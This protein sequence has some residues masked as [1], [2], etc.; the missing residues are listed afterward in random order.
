MIMEEIIKR[1]LAR[2][3]E[4]LF[5]KE[6]SSFE[7]VGAYLSRI[8]RTDSEI[9]AFLH[10]N[11]EKALSWAKESDKRRARGETLGAFDGIP[12]ALKDNICTRDM[13]T[14]CASKMLED[15]TPPYDAYVTEKLRD[16]GFI[17]IGKTNMDEF[18]MGSTGEHSA[19]KIIRNPRNIKHSAG[20]SSGGS[21]AA[22]SAYQVPATLGSDTGGSVRLPAA[23]CGAV[24]LKPTYGRISRYGLVAFASSLDQIGPITHT[25]RD[26]ASL[27]DVIQGKDAHDETSFDYKDT[28]EDTSFSLKGARI[29]LLRELFDV[30]IDGEVRSA[31]FKVAKHLEALGAEVSEISLPS[32]KHALPAYYIISCAEASSNLSRFDSVR[33]GKR[34]KGAATQEELYKLSRSE[35][36]GNEVKRRILLGSYL[37]SEG[38]REKYY[39]KALATRELI[40][41]EF[42]EAFSRFDAVLCPTAPTTAPLIAQKRDNVTDVYAEDICCVPANIAGIPALTI[43]CGKDA[44]GLPIGAELMGAANSEAKLYRIAEA[45]EEVMSE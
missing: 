2:H 17:L 6:Y 1:S 25:V 36:L 13:P 3:S 42:R 35:Y 23:F 16:A 10:V 19:F 33:Y 28:K 27:F 43:P 37:L 20:G 4:A 7:L 39:K 26:N 45:L 24:A 32:L 44:A 31:L 15:Y 34:A 9:G 21:A 11:A 30:S 22:V 41:K 18:A 5:K 38:Y 40:K 29:A 8:E 14:T 12:I